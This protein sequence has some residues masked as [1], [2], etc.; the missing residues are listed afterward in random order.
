MKATLLVITDGRINCLDQS[1]PAFDL[2]VDQQFIDQ[3]VIVDDSGD[4]SYGEWIDEAFDFDLRL[5]HDQRRGYA[6]AI[7]TGWDALFDAE[8]IFHLEDD[9]ML[10]RHVP[11]RSMLEV[12]AGRPHFAQMA[13][14]RQAWGPDEVMAGGYLGQDPSAYTDCWEVQRPERRWLEHRKFFT[15]N[16]CIYPQWVHRRGWPQVP[17]SEDAFGT[18]LFNCPQVAC[19]VWGNRHDQPWAIHIGHERIGNGY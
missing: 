14:R 5:S 12:L 9:F 4:P 11:L 10:T 2:S 13:L 8:F 16:P 3:R 15:T 18:E 6:A 1:M 19:G 7:R 17:H